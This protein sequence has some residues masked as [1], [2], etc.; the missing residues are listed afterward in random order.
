M[1]LYFYVMGNSGKKKHR[2]GMISHVVHHAA[3]GHKALTAA[4]THFSVFK[5]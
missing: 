3:T 4:I 1:H 5:G 2:N